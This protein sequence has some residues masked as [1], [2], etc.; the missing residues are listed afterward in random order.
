MR[1]RPIIP[2]ATLAIAAVVG[3]ATAARPPLTLPAPPPDKARLVVYCDNNPVSDPSWTTVSL[4]RT[5]LGSIGPGNVFYRDVTPGTYEI[6][7]RSEQ[8]YPNQAKALSVGPGTTTFINVQV[9]LGWGKS[10][11][12]PTRP[13]T[14]VIVDPAIAERAIAPLHL[15]GG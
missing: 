13:F 1:H 6:E 12:K 5:P 11:S 3:C 4:N 14:L 2:M 10:E 8:L 9:V 15:M 7:V